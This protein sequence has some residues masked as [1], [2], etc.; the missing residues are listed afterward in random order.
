M[1]LISSM[2]DTMISFGALACLGGLGLMASL[3]FAGPGAILLIV[4]LLMVILGFGT[5]IGCLVI[6]RLS[7]PSDPIAHQQRPL[8]SRHAA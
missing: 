8:A 3:I 6:H 4:G 7:E 1:H 5:R 2:A